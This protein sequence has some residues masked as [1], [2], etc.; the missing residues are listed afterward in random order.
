MSAVHPEIGICPL[1]GDA[2]VRIGPKSYYCSN[3]V[4]TKKRC[5]FFLPKELKSCLIPETVARQLIETG[6]TEMI[7][8][9]YSKWGEPFKA[10]LVMK[11]NGWDFDFPPRLEKK[12]PK[13]G[14]GDMTSEI[15][16]SRATSRFRGP[17]TSRLREMMDRYDRQ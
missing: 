2:P 9:F 8:G 4:G 14:S 12:Q 5:S 10:R 17:S 11:D 16:R 3:A 7:K 6:R 13:G 15:A 1:C